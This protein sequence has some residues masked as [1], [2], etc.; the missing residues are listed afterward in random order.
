MK[1]ALLVLLAACGSASRAPSVPPAAAVPHA[2]AAPSVA[3]TWQDV[4]GVRWGVD[5]S[6]HGFDVS[7][8]DHGAVT[9]LENG[10]HPHT[11][12]GVPALAAPLP[13]TP[14]IEDADRA[15]ATDTAKDGADGWARNFDDHGAMWRK[16]HRVE[17][18]DIRASIEKTLAAGALR[19]EPVTSGARGDLGFSLG[20]ATFTEAGGAPE[21]LT[22]CTIWKHEP[23]GSWK[24]LFDIGRPAE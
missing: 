2:P 6:D 13:R 4:G 21:K 17:G 18:A 3:S 1:R 12:Q 14:A 10:D 5:L 11:M 16:D 23:D 20:T 19:W 7:Y 15:F 22:Y 24:V 9:S 8:V